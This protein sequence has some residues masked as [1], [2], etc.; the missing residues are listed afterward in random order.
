MRDR[1]LEALIEDELASVAGLAG[2]SMLGGW[3]WLLHGNLLC[4]AREEGMLVR[5][6]KASA[7]H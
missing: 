1:G 4:G 5:P 7:P 2:K 6:G 3:M